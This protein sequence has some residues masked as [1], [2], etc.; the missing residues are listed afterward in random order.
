MASHRRPCGN[1]QREGPGR[2]GRTG[3]PLTMEV[4]LPCYVGTPPRFATAFDLANRKRSTAMVRSQ[5][6][7]RVAVAEPESTKLPLTV[8]SMG[9]IWTS[10]RCFRLGQ[11]RPTLHRRV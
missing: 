9:I 3:P 5:K 4:G 10:W 11:T 7:V 8:L 2:S 6:G 1:E